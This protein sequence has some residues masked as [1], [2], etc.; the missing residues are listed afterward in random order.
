MIPKPRDARLVV[1]KKRASPRLKDFKAL[2]RSYCD[3]EESQSTN[4]KTLIHTHTG[5]RTPG[6]K[7]YQKRERGLIE[8]FHLR[9]R[10][11]KK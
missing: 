6:Q 4:T 3:L 9:G 2:S 5:A 7:Y 1:T 11:R 10:K 8:I